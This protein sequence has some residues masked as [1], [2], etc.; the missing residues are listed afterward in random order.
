MS[1]AVLAPFWV[2][3]RLYM[4][5]GG[6]MLK[7]IHP[8]PFIVGLHVLKQSPFVR[9]FMVVDEVVVQQNPGP[10]IQGIYLLIREF[11][12]APLL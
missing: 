5:S 11:Y 1:E 7:R 12:L 10:R 6:H 4:E 8:K 9:Y 3:D 2:V